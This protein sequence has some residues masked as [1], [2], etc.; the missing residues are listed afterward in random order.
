MRGDGDDGG[1][2][3]SEGSAAGQKDRRGISVSEDLERSR[4]RGA[5]GMG[6]RRA[7]A[8]TGRARS[9]GN[10]G[11]APLVVVVVVV[12]PTSCRGV[13]GGDHEVRGEAVRVCVFFFPLGCP[14]TNLPL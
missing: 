14:R 3:R 1:R 7:A 5:D 10:V 13:C 8:W 6:L 9:V 11:R 2:R 12:V 4:L